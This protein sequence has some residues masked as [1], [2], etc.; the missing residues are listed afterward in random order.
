MKSKFFRHPTEKILIFILIA[1]LG[2]FA[3]ILWDYGQHINNLQTQNDI[4][5]RENFA[6][7]VYVQDADKGLYRNSGVVDPLTSRVYIPEIKV[8]LPLGQTTRDLRYFSD[9]TNGNQATEAEFSSATS[10][11]RLVNSFAEVPCQQRL[12]GL[13]VGAISNDLKSMYGQAAGSLKLADG[14]T[15]YF[16][17]SNSTGCTNFWQTTPQNVISALKQAQPY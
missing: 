9:A 13:S 5:Q 3:A 7:K 15:L 17:E 8:Y 14:R 4:T 6:V 11:N 12:A 10:L 2:L 1:I 16:Y